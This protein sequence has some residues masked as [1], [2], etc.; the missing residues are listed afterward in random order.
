[1]LVLL[2]L[3]VNAPFPTPPGES[4]VVAAPGASLELEGDSTLRRY[5]ARATEWTVEVRV[6]A[7]RVAATAQ[8]LDVEGLIRGHFIDVFALVVPVDKLGS[9]DGRLDRHLHEALA[10]SPQ[11]DS[12]PDGLVRYRR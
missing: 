12:V 4:K 2:A 8:S 3:L 11:R 10:G 9:G 5:G 7:A 1:M 6:D